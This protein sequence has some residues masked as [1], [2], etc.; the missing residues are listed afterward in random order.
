[1]SNTKEVL[2]PADKAVVR[3][4]EW[5]KRWD[6]KGWKIDVEALRARRG[7]IAF[8]IPCPDRR[9]SGNW[10]LDPV[11]LVPATEEQAGTGR[12]SAAG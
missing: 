12:Q 11:P 7:D 6:A 10:V 8:A 5:L 9:T 1:M 3:Y 2:M 4:R